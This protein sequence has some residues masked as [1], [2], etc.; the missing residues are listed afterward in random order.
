M[1]K[2]KK[3]DRKHPS[4]PFPNK[5]IEIDEGVFG[6]RLSDR[7]EMPQSRLAELLDTIN[8]FDLVFDDEDDENSELEFFIDTDDFD[9]DEF[10]GKIAAI[11]NTEDIEVT[12]KN[13]KT[14]LTYLIQNMN[15]P[16]QVTPTDEFEWEEYYLYGAG[17]NKEYEKQKKTN[18]SYTDIFKLIRFEEEVTEEEGIKVQVERC[19]DRRKFILPLCDLEGVDEN[20]PNYEFLDDY[21][22]WFIN[23]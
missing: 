1:S 22:L 10:D 23:Y 15:I 6:A 8:N 9:E 3:P 16:C 17:S 18:P 13:L 11:L 19:S 7:G 20:L 4:T 14:Y 5:V 2:S 12:E 21:V